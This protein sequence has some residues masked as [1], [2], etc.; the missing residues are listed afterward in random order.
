MMRTRESWWPPFM[1]DAEIPD[2]IGPAARWVIAGV[3]IF[4]FV[5]GAS[6][7]FREGKPEAGW[8]YTALFV[9]SFVIAVFWNRIASFAKGKAKAM[10]Y[11]LG[12]IALLA[13]GVAIGMSIGRREF[14]T[15]ASIGNVVWNF[16]QTAHGNGYFLNMQKVGNQELRV[17]GFGA[18]GK[19]ITSGPIT[20]FS[21]YMRS[22]QTNVT[23]PIYIVAQDPDETKVQACFAQA[24]IPTIPQETYGIPGFADFDISTFE[25]PFIETGIDGVTITKFM[26]DY[27]PFTIVLEYDGTKY[28][29]RFSKEEVENQV[30]ILNRSTNPQSTP[31]VMR[32]VDAKPPPL[33]PLTTLIPRDP[34]NILPGLASP[35]PQAGLP[36]IPN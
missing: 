5:L 3:F 14:A 24:M 29:R 10:L 9:I 27:V 7:S 2:R 8:I 16:E 36:K 17:T 13:A 11:A 23:L 18:H 33:T 30:A 21:G 32:K 25:K 1:S 19:N 4:V 34:P 20:K 28:E 12:V 26:N 35:I 6:D 15:P 31:R 22:E